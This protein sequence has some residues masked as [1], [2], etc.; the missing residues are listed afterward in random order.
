MRLTKRVRL[1]AIPLTQARPVVG[2]TSIKRHGERIDLVTPLAPPRTSSVEWY[3]AGMVTWGSRV[4]CSELDKGNTYFPLQPPP[5]SEF[6]SSVGRTSPAPGSPASARS[7]EP[8][9]ALTR[10]PARHTSTYDPAGT[11]QGEGPEGP[12]FDA[13]FG[14]LSA[15]QGSPVAPEPRGEGGGPGRSPWPSLPRGP[16]PSRSP[17]SAT[18]DLRAPR[19]LSL[20]F[21]RSSPPAQG[22]PWLALL[23]GAM[24]TS[25][26]PSASTPGL[27][28][29]GQPASLPASPRLAGRAA[30]PAFAVGHG[31]LAVT[32]DPQGRRHA[33]RS[34]NA[35]VPGRH[36][37]SPGRPDLHP[38]P[39]P[40]DDRAILPRRAFRPRGPH[41]RNFTSNAIPRPNDTQSGPW[42]GSE[43]FDRPCLPLVAG[44]LSSSKS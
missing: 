39:Q 20:A 33:R 2:L 19:L 12:A 22:F 42:C 30:G 34:S 28:T 5:G 7:R 6:Q 21:P 26:R 14:A 1:E 41:C 25:T 15:D 8:F 37:G 40:A 44:F 9:S 23:P 3:V 35:S 38:G 29:P 10:F 17:V 27:L 31:G 13:P 24:G 11:L 43:V 36:S 32:V 18:A 16:P 4:R